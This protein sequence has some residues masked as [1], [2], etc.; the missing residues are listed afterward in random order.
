[1][2]VAIINVHLKPEFIAAFKVA[3]LDNASNSIKEPGVVRFDVYQQTDD[4]TH[5][6]L[7]EIYKTE[8]DVDRHRATSHY[9]RWRDAVADMMAEPRDRKT[10]N[11]IFPPEGQ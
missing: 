1:M 2:V 4:P 9:V 6:V 8:Q 10:Y 11:F 3:I 5:F 7:A